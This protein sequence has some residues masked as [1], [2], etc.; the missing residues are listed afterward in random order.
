MIS[1]FLFSISKCHKLSLKPNE[2][3]GNLLF[4]QN[5]SPESTQSYACKK[6][7]HKTASERC[8]CLSRLQFLWPFNWGF[9]KKARERGKIEIKICLP[10]K[11]K[12]I[13]HSSI[14]EH[15]WRNKLLNK[16]GD[17]QNFK[18]HLRG[19]CKKIKC[20]KKTIAAKGIGG[21]LYADFIAEMDFPKEV[22]SWQN[23]LEMVKF[24]VRC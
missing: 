3:N 24:K 4:K 19:N 17:L 22:V 7:E 13:I 14:V 11:L 21:K 8:K 15:S 5:N 20:E 10:T 16:T 18:I 9:L 1:I 12:Q 23:Y 6:Q 2:N